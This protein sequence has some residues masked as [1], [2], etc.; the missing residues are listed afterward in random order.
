MEALMCILKDS[1]WSYNFKLNASRKLL[2]LFFAHPVSIHL[3]WI[4]HH[5]ALLD[6]T[7]KTNRYKLPLLHVIGQAASNQLFTIVFCFLAYKDKE[8]YKW[9]V[10]N[11]KSLIWRP[12]QTP[13]VFITN[14][15]SALQNAL[16]KVFPYSQTDLCTWHLNKNIT[17]KCKKH[18]TAGNSEFGKKFYCFGRLSLTP[19]L[20]TNTMTTIP[21]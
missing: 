3:A 14:C 13:K 4:N 15:D 11:L 21:I 1:N 9:A 19:K 6:A 16:A 10:M 5:V 12:D 2:N 7:Y 18:F 8:N 20:G 17:T